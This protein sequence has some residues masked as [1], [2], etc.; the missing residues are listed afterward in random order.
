MLRCLARL[1]K[2]FFGLCAVFHLSSSAVYAQG[3]R[4]VDEQWVW[5]AA[6]GAVNQSSANLSDGPGDVA[7]TRGYLSGG[8][9]YAWDRDTSVS[10]SLGAGTTDYDFSSAALIEGRKPWGRIR[11]YRLSM[12]V[13]FAP[14]EKMSVIAIPSIRTYAESG[15]SLRDGRTEGLLGGFSWK[16]SNTLS[17]GPGFGWFS[18]VGDESNVFPIVLVDWKITESL[19]LNTGRGLA[20][21]QGPGLSLNYAVNPKWTLGLSAR[22]E[23]IRFSL[24]ERE[25]RSAAVG[26]DS[27]TPL[28][29]VASYSPWPMTSVTAL[30]GADIGGTLSLEDGNGQRLSKADIDTA[31]VFGVTFKSRF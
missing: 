28:Y 20:A 23:K 21:S 8:L 9:G 17:I 13:R 18:D 14:F 31:L 1:N 2:A 22:Y 6:G 3:D 7:I 16:F 29:I 24:K 26:E 5:S 30:A 25:G 12:P 10:A 11:D 27:S 15:A 19:S 4:R